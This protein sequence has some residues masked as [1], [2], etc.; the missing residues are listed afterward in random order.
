MDPQ[1][2]PTR[3]PTNNRE[4]GKVGGDRRHL[5]DLFGGDSARRR[6]R[7]HGHRLLHLVP[8]F[9]WL[10]FFLGGWAGG[11]EEGLGGRGS[12]EC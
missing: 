6:L 1:Q 3:S 7:L 11:L 8:P 9:C 12:G 4:R 5:L 2:H 10:W